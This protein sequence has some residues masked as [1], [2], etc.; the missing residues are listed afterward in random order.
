MSRK[1]APFFFIP[2]LLN[3]WINSMIPFVHSFVMA[4]HWK[5]YDGIVMY[6][7]HKID[8]WHYLFKD[9]R[10]ISSTQNHRQIH[11]FDW[12]LIEG[13][14]E[15][16][17][18]FVIGSD[19]NSVWMDGTPNHTIFCLKRIECVIDL[20]TFSN[21]TQTHQFTYTANERERKTNRVKMS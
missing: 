11:E 12:N 16:R 10:S 20:Y 2:I 21:T 3:R 15:N 13:T 17:S 5:V 14:T 7:H 18:S 9:L 4:I 8:L 1:F 6:A 19:W